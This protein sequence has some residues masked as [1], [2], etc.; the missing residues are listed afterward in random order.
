MLVRG[1]QRGLGDRR[2]VVRA[3]DPLGEQKVPEERGEEEVLPE[4]LLEEVARQR[5]PRDRVRD[6]REDPVQLPEHGAAVSKLA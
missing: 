1:G 2:A 5:V 4:E 6:G 3:H